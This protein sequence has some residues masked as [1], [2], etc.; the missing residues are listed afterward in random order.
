MLAHRNREFAGII[1]NADLP[2]PDGVG[3]VLSKLI[4]G[5]KKRNRVTGVDLIEK[6]CAKSV[7]MPI[8][9]GF[10]GGFHNVAEIVTKRQ[11]K[12]KV[13]PSGIRTKRV[14]IMSDQS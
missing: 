3:I 5:G 9:I 11:L 10:L 13:E 14:L 1:D 7:D 2:L 8:R 4:M 12:L 6:I